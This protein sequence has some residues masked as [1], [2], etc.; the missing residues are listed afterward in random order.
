MDAVR[1]FSDRAAAVR[2]DIETPEPSRVPGR[3]GYGW[4]DFAG[5]PNTRDL[6]GL[7]GADGRRVKRG[8]LLRS[9]T[10][11]FG[12]DADVARL[13]DEYDVRL[14]VDLRGTEELIEL[15]DPMAELPR[16]RY[17]HADIL[18]KKAEGITQDRDSREMARLREEA[19]DDPVS[20]MELVYPHLLLDEPGVAGYRSFFES[21]LACDEGSALWHCY[22]G[23]D[24]CG[25]ASALVEAALGVDEGEMGRDYLATN[26]YAPREI[27]ESSP[28]SMRSFRAARRAVTDEFGGFTGYI[29]RCL[30]F[31]PEAIEELR[32]RYLE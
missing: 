5:L 9:G 32:A 16:A 12:T 25:M 22:V 19:G 21:L 14:V 18:G 28:A 30:G 7:V 8:R 11:G 6:G 31:G 1:E 27:T 26:V 24:R 15:P 4:I 20:F 2:G 13:R 10:L 29:E 17:V 3:E 23:R